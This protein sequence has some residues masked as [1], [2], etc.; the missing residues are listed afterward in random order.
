MLAD[1]ASIL[2]FHIVLIA[3]SAALV[4]GWLMT[5]DHLVT[6]ALVGGV[7]WL[8]I[9]LLNRITDLEEDAAN[10]I[11]GTGLVARR[12]RAFWAAFWILFVGSFAFSAVAYP[13]LTAL[14]VIVQAIGL[15]YSLALVPTPRGLRRFKDL[16]FLKNFMSSV[17]FVLTCFVYPLATTGFEIALPGGLAAV[18]V[19]VGFFVT[20]ELTYEILY[21]LRDLEGDRLAGVPTYPVVHGER[22]SLRIIDGLLGVSVAVL[23][24]GL[25]TG[26]VGVREGLMLAAPAIQFA[27]YRPLVRRGLSSRDCIGL[28][29]L[30]SA[31]LVFFIIGNAIWLALGLPE[32]IYL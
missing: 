16:Y 27:V 31:L 9:N 24:A 12:P 7:D 30:G 5:G 20:F 13:E 28:T 11:R 10:E 23:G 1:L 15:G 32:N 18:V 25:V 6:V 3:V 2:R 29:H 17:L 8:L 26:L 22:L 21:D 14:R 19:L 4:F